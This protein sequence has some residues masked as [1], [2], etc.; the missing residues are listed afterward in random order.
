MLDYLMVT[1]EN[2]YRS[3]ILQTEKVVLS[4]LGIYTC[5][6]VCVCV[7]VCMCVCACACMCVCA[8]IYTTNIRVCMYVCMCVC[9]YTY[10]SNAIAMIFLKDNEF[11]R[12]Q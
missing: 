7:C 10:I 6:C 9:K 12:E 8:R 2:K 11:Q 4:S 1:P 3:N 5:V